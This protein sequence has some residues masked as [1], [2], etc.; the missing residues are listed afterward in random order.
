MRRIAARIFLGLVALVLANAALA[1]DYRYHLYIDR[2][3]NV[4]TGCS[5]TIGA[6]TIDGAEL[7]VTAN[8]TGTTVTTVTRADCAGALF[9]GETAIGG[10]HPVGLNN[11]VSGADVIEFAIDRG[12]V[13]SSNVIHLSLAASN[14]A[15][16]S[17]DVLTTAAGGG[18]ILQALIQFAIPA[19]G[20]LG[21]V[22]LVAAFAFVASRRLKV[23]LASLGA[24]LMASAVWAAN[25]VVDG[26]VG[27]WSGVPA[28]ASDAQG[29]A[30]GADPGAEIYA[31]FAAEEGGRLYYRVDVADVEN[32]VPVAQPQSLTFL[33]DSAAQ[34]ITL[35]ATDGDGDPLTYA[36]GA[37]APTKGVLSGFNATTGA[38]TYTPNANAEGADNFTFTATDGLAT[39]APATIS[40]T[41]TPVNDAPVAT[42][43]MFSTPENTPN[44]T[45]VGT[46]I[47]A[48]DIDTTAPNNTLSF[49]I[50]A[51]NTAGA[52]AI[53]ASSGQITVANSTA[54]DFKTN[55]SFAL[56]ITV[57][58]GG[59]G[60]L[61]D[62][63]AVTIN[64]GNVNEPPVFQS[65]PYV[66]SLPENS[67]VATVVGQTPALD[68]DTTAPNNTLT[69]AI[70]SGNAS[71]AF[72]INPTTGA[73]SVANSTPL[74]FETTTSFTLGISVT[75]GGTPTGSD[76]STVTINVTDVNEAPVVTGGTFTLPENSANTTAVGT[77]TA[78]DVDLPAQAF[79][80]AITA[81]NTGGAF[82]INPAT[83]AITVATTAAL[84][85]E[86]NPS[87]ALTVQ[88]TD[89]GAPTASGT[90]L[91]T[92]NLTNVN[93]APTFTGEPYTANVGENTANGT[94]VTNVVTATDVDAATTLTYAITGGNTSGA[95]AIAAG[96]G[97][98]TV[99]NSTALDFKVNPSFTLNLS[100]TDNGA[101]T[102][103]SDTSTITI[104]VGDVNEAPV[105]Q[106][107]PYA[108][109][110]AEN[111]V[112]ATAVGSTPATDQDV[113]AQTLTYAITGG[114]TGGT[115]AIGAGGA[116]TV[117]VPPNF[118]VTPSYTLNISVTDNGAGALSDTSTVAITITNVNEAP[119]NAVPVGPLS[120][121]VSVPLA[122]TGPNSISIAD[123][124]AAAGAVTTTIS[125]TLGTFTATAVN[126]ATVIGSGT[127]S[128]AITDIVADVN[129]TLQTLSF[130][131]AGGGSATV[132]VLTSDNGNTG[133]GGTQSD[134]DNFSINIDAAPTVTAVTPINAA[135]NQAGN[136]N[137]TVTFSEAV[138]VTGNWFQI[139]CPTSG[140]RN[141]V[142]TV[143]T[144]GPTTFT[145]NPN[146]D[147][148]GGETCTTTIFAAQV[149][150]QDAI[151][152]PANLPANF[153]WSFAT[154]V[155]PTVTAFTP[156]NGAT[157]Q[158]GNTN[159]TVTFSE[160]VNVT[161]NWF[162]IVCT[163]SGTRNVA[164]TVVTGGPTTFTINP[165]VDFAGGD[166]CTTTVFAAQVA[167]QDG[168]DP[169]DTMAANF[170]ASF[171]TDAAPS[172]TT[173]T[174]TNGATSQA[175]S[176]NLTITFSEAVNVS[177]N[178]FQI[179]CATSGTR[180]VADTVVTGGPTTFTINPNI[181]FA[182]GELCT[183]TVFAAQ[184]AD[185]DGNDPPDNMLANFV[186]SFTTDVAP[187]VTA[188]TPGNGGTV[189]TAD[190]LSVTFSEPVNVSGNWFQI[191]CTI[192]GTRNVV[193]TVVTGGPTTFTINPNVD[194]TPGDN[195]TATITAGQVSDQD[196][197]DPPDTMGANFFWSFTTDIA[198][199]VTATT[200]IASA[201]VPN[202]QAL[203]VTFSE[204]I[205]TTAAAVTLSCNGGP[206]LITGGSTGT[207][208]GSLTPTYV[209]P[210]PS[211]NCVMTVIAA[212]VFDTDLADPPDFMV[213]NT[214]VNFSVD[215][216][217]AVLSITPNNGSTNQSN[218][219]PIVITFN[220]SVA[221]TGSAFTVECPVGS[222]IA[223]TASASPATVYT[224]TP[225][226]SWPGGN[227]CT[228]TVVAGQISDSDVVDPPQNMAANFVSTFASD[229]A[230]IFIS[231][232]PLAAATNVA[233]STNVTFTFDENVDDLGGAITLNCAGA[234]A[235]AITGSGTPTLTFNPTVDLPAGTPCTATAVAL[236]IGDTDANDPPNN[237]A[238]NVI[239][240]FTTDAPPSVSNT[241]PA[242]GATAQAATG[243]IT[244]NFSES[245]NFSTVANVANTS[246]D[247]ECP[248]GIPTNFTVSTASPAASVV[249]D[250]LDSAIAGQT[251]TLSVRAVGIT[252]QDAG[253]PPDNMPADFVASF[254]FSGV[255]NDD[256]FT[257]TPHLTFATA[258]GATEVD[259]NDVLG[260]EVITSF[261]FGAGICTGTSAGTQ[262]D[263]GAANGRLTLNANGTYSY[264]PPAGVANTT[265]T[266]CYT[267]SGGDTANV[268]FTLANTEL[269]WFVDTTAAA[270]GIGNQARPFQTL[271][272]AAGVDTT[273]D[274]I[275]LADGNY[276]STITL[277]TGERLIGDGSSGALVTHTG[278]TPV[279]GSVF[280]V[281]S[282]TAPVI[283][284]GG[285]CITVPAA[286]N[287][288]LRGFT[289][290]DSGTTGTD[291]SGTT[292][293]TLTLNEVTLNGNGRALDLFTGTL[294]GNFI[295]IDVST[296][297]EQGILLNTVGGTWT[298]T[299][300][301]NFGNAGT[302]GLPGI[303]IRNAPASANMTLTAGVVIAK[304]SAANALQLLQNAGAA[305]LNVGVV[306]ISNSN[307]FGI[308]V[309]TSPVTF[310]GT[311][312]TISAINGPA[313]NANNATFTGG[314]TFAT[315]TCNPCGN[316]GINLNTVVGD[317]TINGGS[318]L[319]SATGSPFVVNAGASNITYAGS[320]STTAATRL[321]DITART[322]GTIAL[323][324]NLS[325][326][327][328]STGINIANNTGGTINLSGATK[329]LT[330]GT[331]AA[332][333]LATNT[334]SNI[335]FTGGGLGITTTS[336]AGFNATSGAAGIS[337]T[338]AAN[339]I[340]STTGTAL[341]VNATTI[342]A[343][344]LTFQSINSA[345][346]SANQVISLANTG[347]GPV[348]VTGTGAAGTGGT[349][350]NKTD[351]AIRLNNT[352]GLIT[353]DRMIIEDI[354][355][356]AGASNTI[357]THDAIHGQDVNAGLSLTGTTIRR[358]SDQAIHG[359]TLAGGLQTVWNG[360]RL[361]SVVIEDSNRFH[362]ANVGDANNEGT[363][364][365]LGLRGTV[366]INN[367]TFLRGGEFLDTFVT[368]GT[369][370]MTVTNS[371]FTNAYKEFTVGT[372]ASV[373]GHC[374]DVVVQ[375]AGAA[376]V[377]I[378][379]RAAGPNSNIFLNCRLG[380]LRFVNDT[381]S[382]GNSDFIVARNTFTVNDGS[383]GI[384]GD[385]DF[386][387]GG[388]MAW[389]LGNGP[390][391]SVVDT[392]VENNTFTDVTNAS[393]GVGQ[394]TLIAEGGLLQALVQNN[395]F[396]RP[397]NAPWWIQSRNTV[398]SNAR[399]RFANNTVTGG[400]SL[401]TADPS[402]AG[403]YSTPG[404][405]TLFD[406]NNGATMDAVLDTNSF[407]G[408]DTGFDPGQTVEFRGLLP[409]GGNF[410]VDM[411]SNQADDGYA[412][413][414]QAGTMRT[415]G[416][417]TCPTGSPSA[418]CQ[419][420]LGN[421][422]NRGGANSLLTN[423]PFVNVPF[424][425]VTVSGVTCAIPT[426]GPF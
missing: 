252:D 24:L 384:G 133:S 86:T 186:S 20:L 278:I 175:T 122:F 405:R 152:P 102:N 358:I 189:L 54:L 351:D 240:N 207:N 259:A 268:V 406:S 159:L 280:P 344:G 266:F 366:T 269:V 285:I 363:I 423:P 34:P 6:T 306:T 13:G 376:N 294:T 99:A 337:V 301:L 231:A 243:T 142:D 128:V 110:I 70:I 242:N 372:L 84:D 308:S 131:S 187:S 211:G 11:G 166:T 106:S 220:E 217:P 291:I 197:G 281:F 422:N 75:D 279:L 222:P 12:L 287:N 394:L 134:S 415:V 228:V 276:T 205:S 188:T 339:T 264:E 64:L 371:S 385:F 40:I 302:A 367:S 388:V 425:P 76:T 123:V 324:G 354:G 213:A 92:V 44:G 95:F 341:N 226:T 101:P 408:H 420:V 146:A 379:N 182:N 237:P 117:A 206:N 232:T 370:N 96:T 80:W 241:V 328:T 375:G 320:I 113:P 335:N 23:G 209:A 316:E 65:E 26:A 347:A 413:E 292:F 68:Q 156:L 224:L 397:G 204:N 411:T 10:P 219:V 139:V 365:I 334:G 108:F 256:A 198:P 383:S 129:L 72:A 5:E 56:T 409:G 378:G 1:Q 37:V 61:S 214:V 342:A 169:P 203:N 296:S 45:N 137:L 118:E 377:T 295:D 253:D 303:M 107:E 239:R 194:F 398:N 350:D 19:L 82:A 310:I 151:D 349:I 304:A 267:V 172:V 161:G 250:P 127:N 41:L 329:T 255:A 62:T 147:F 158:A 348:S 60:P 426:G 262:L 270:G 362:V 403:G 315:V 81:G 38:V 85:F 221:A 325:A 290:A 249:L 352:G 392:I 125:T 298:V 257:V 52:F 234:V 218:S 245:V 293:G 369:L 212:N 36:L 15:G 114:N 71:G 97:V 46:P 227:T 157:N 173:L 246:F 215:D 277:E 338:G 416:A 201:M 326:T 67:A 355:N 94:T 282:A 196:A 150:D 327:G 192:S 4:A 202:T 73:I 233:T 55:P 116:I 261:G 25:F 401:C 174:P 66:F 48:T 3:A 254:S 135:T 58:D 51:G 399:V 130:S 87:F 164:D 17:S 271:T 49:A 216:V 176:A 323:T 340:T 321:I 180:N 28:V 93:E 77:A 42:D 78:T 360:L 274:S 387:M 160:P 199:T 162:Q 109:S 417:G 90:A 170:V 364:R 314:A 319:G 22:L 356:M 265:R 191:V 190:N 312:G 424:T 105:F 120:T 410:C 126:G 103:L 343:T 418:A 248:S 124:D 171:S 247:L 149:D 79:T 238:A 393:G 322:G 311:T 286:G 361:E 47:V 181:D 332:V 183:T 357:S 143:V 39:S 29:D 33:E 35:I 138:N 121:G 7:R 91:F 167:D 208:V 235:G 419:T 407:A 74:N 386:P 412:L 2:D 309:D 389:N 313:I 148:A 178:W 353:L 297:T 345:T 30:V 165:N 200:P 185:Q 88:A 69:W 177:G 21:L 104:T 359:A 263:A 346:A 145:I 373:G 9:G 305:T 421:R 284:C 153:V 50:T 59:A 236:S 16:T 251:C 390:G 307:G 382:T 140:T 193:D 402:C 258:N 8:V 168:N 380:S 396:V 272:A 31:L 414:V 136:T 331:N 115:F 400:P 27:D 318:L 229:A 83:G 395:S 53:N 119:V 14:G 144:G 179:V 63:A 273:N 288:F 289:V 368:A 163:V 155:A 210:L 333:T 141:V 32:Q 244:V 330:T 381:A 195:C 317:L 299:N 184:I 43:A 336:G 374:I 89:N 98:I 18:P 223:F 57:T 111:S 300:P 391:G 230:P 112:P 154:D 404:L 275:F 100:V 225:N 132:T 283:S 260:A